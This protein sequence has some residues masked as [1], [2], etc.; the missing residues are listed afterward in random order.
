M[1]AKMTSSNG[2]LPDD[3]LAGC[4]KRAAEY[5]ASL[6]EDG[7]T[8]GLGTGSTSKFAIEALGK[9][10]REGLAIKGVPTSV[11]TER[12]ATEQGISLV[13]LAEASRIDIAI[14]GADEVDSNLDMI[15]GGGG[16][17]AREKLVA[18]ASKRR[19]MVVDWTKLVTTL[20]L[21][22]KLPVEVLRFA[23]PLS[24][25]L[26][27]ELGC[28]PQL[29]L[30]GESPFETDNGNYIIDCKFEGIADA[31]SLEKRIKLLPGVVDSGLFVGIAD[32]L[33]IGFVDRVEERHR[34]K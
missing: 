20:G 24:A 30:K 21:S 3:L 5:A 18:L 15:K 9:R 8:V 7:Q 29:R 34:I 14:D 11:A 27:G 4:K 32:L 26:L 6:V 1:E 16:A 2:E 31:A 22:F 13:S 33:V 12:L 10:V 28:H 23:W 25:R 19:V 17:L